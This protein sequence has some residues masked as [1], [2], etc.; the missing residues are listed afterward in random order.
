MW[1]I[2]VNTGTDGLDV[3]MFVARKG[4]PWETEQVLIEG[5]RNSTHNTPEYLETAVCQY[6]SYFSKLKIF[7]DHE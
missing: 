1:S 7:I 6:P 2:G 3:L 4:Y 5:V